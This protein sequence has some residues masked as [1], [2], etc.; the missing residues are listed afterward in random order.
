MPAPGRARRGLHA[1]GLA[2]V[3]A[4]RGGGRG[5]PSL[6]RARH[7][8]RPRRGSGRCRAMA[9]PARRSPEAAGRCYR[10]TVWFV[11]PLTF[12][13]RTLPPVRIVTL[14]GE[15]ALPPEP[16]WTSAESL[17]ELALTFTVPFI[18]A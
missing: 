7:T 15:Y 9:L 2:L 17:V 8:A 4:M 5:W 18:P 16:T 12:T 10:V 3:R 1:N 6:W 14:A 11:S 13:Q